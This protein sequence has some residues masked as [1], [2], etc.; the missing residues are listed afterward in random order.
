MAV[1]QRQGQRPDGP[2]HYSSV[3]Y[4]LEEREET[5]YISTHAGASAFAD[6]HGG[7]VSAWEELGTAE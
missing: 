6:E 2:D 4:H 7:E 3:D 5:Q 1:R